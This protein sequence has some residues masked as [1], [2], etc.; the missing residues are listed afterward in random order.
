MK[1]QARCRKRSCQARRN[2]NKR[3]SEYARPPKCHVQGCDGL[4]REDKV[5]V[6]GEEKRTPVC[7]DPF[8]TYEEKHFRETGK[9]V[10][11]HR[12]STRGCSGYTQ[13]VIEGEKRG[14]SPQTEEC[15]W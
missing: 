7:H 8:C 6:R 9:W 11:Y 13:W 2:L 5:R 1:V 10:P 14:V 12:V 15:P 4:M 3:I